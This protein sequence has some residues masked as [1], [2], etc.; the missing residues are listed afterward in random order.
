[1]IWNYK[2]YL[3]LLQDFYGKW[4]NDC[5]SALMITMFEGVLFAY[6]VNFSIENSYIFLRLSQGFYIRWF[7]DCPSALM[8]TIFES[9]LC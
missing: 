4:F 9:V 6:H 5:P 2:Y 8:N 1:M 3:R 7:N